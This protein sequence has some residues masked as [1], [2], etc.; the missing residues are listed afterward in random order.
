MTVPTFQ[1]ASLRVSGDVAEFVHTR[2]EA[3]NP[4]GQALREDYVR[5]LDWMG[6]GGRAVRALVLRGEGGNF[7]AGGDVREMAARLQ[8]PQQHTPAQTEAR[9]ASANRWLQQLLGLDA[10]VIAAVDGPAF[11]GGFSLALHADLVLATPRAR[12]CMSFARVGAV[13]D[14]GA[15]CLLP[16]VVGLGVARDL[17]LTARSIDAAEARRLGIVHAV[18]PVEQLSDRALA[19]ARQ[20]ARGPREVFAATKRLLRRS[21]DADYLALGGMEAHAQGLAM[22]APYHH[23]AARRFRDRQ[24]LAYDWDRD[25][26]GPG[27]DK[28][29]HMEPAQRD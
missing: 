15:H 18:H 25:G 22:A 12:F 9:I 5:L 13:P 8:S 14:F 23:D 6:S 27:Y 10:V 1:A 17:L 24:P 20:L 11:G 3:R 26:A 7:S 21:H 2:P 16:R 28:D 29:N 19:A 4:L